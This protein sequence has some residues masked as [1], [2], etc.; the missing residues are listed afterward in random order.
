VAHTPGLWRH[1]SCPIEFSLVVNDLGVKYVRKEHANHLITTLQKDYKLS[2]D[3]TGSLYCG[4]SLDWDYTN[5]TLDILMPGYILK[6]RAKFDH[7][8]PAKPQNSP[9]RA[10]KKQYGKLAQDPIPPNNTPP[11]N[12]VHIKVIQQV[13]GGVLYY[14]QA[15]DMTVLT[16]LSALASNQASATKNNRRP[17]PTTI[18]L[19]SHP[20]KGHHL[21]LQVR[22]DPK[23]SFGRIIL[24]R[25]KSQK[26]CRWVLFSRINTI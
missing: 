13:I 6:L 18:G 1:V 16:A 7:Q 2:K 11:I 20:S 9:H 14:A 12:A 10:P 17:C 19:P 24:I 23:Y 15:V 26:L 25:K 21:L 4:I 22:Y 3:W 5:R 8:K